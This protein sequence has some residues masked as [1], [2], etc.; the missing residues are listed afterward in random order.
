MVV[1]RGKW[2][3]L[4]ENTGEGNEVVEEILAG[5]KA[6]SDRRCFLSVFVDQ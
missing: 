4:S 6:K 2:V 3:T 5:G 1:P